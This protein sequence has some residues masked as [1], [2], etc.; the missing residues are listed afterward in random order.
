MGAGSYMG[1]LLFD[2]TGGYTWAY[3]FAAAMGTVN[4]VV[5]A[6]FYISR[7]KQQPALATG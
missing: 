1:G 5:L 4:L 2:L 6:L 7:S 3:A